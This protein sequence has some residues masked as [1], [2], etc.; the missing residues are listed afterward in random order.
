MGIAGILAEL[1]IASHTESPAQWIPIG[2]AGVGVA[3]FWAHVMAA[4]PATGRVLRVLMRLCIAAGTAGIGLS[5]HFDRLVRL[6]RRCENPS[7]ADECGEG[8]VCPGV[9]SARS[10]ARWKNCKASS[11]LPNLESPSPSAV[12]YRI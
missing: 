10:R 4:S 12:G 1:A 11:F 6:A 3:A 2:L 7:L 5:Q 9:E 8:K